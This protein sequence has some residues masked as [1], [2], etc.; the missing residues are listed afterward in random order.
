MLKV[1]GN[2]NFILIKDVGFVV[3]KDFSLKINNVFSKHRVFQQRAKTRIARSVNHD[4]RI[5]E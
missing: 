1:T 5:F 3:E 4:C 2:R